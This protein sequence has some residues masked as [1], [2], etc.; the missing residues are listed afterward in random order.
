MFHIQLSSFLF[1][2]FFPKIQYRPTQLSFFDSSPYELSHMSPLCH[3]RTTSFASSSK[4]AGAKIFLWAPSGSW[5]RLCAAT[6]GAFISTVDKDSTVHLPNLHLP[7]HRDPHSSRPSL[8]DAGV[9][10][11][12]RRPR[13][14]RDA[15]FWRGSPFL[16]T[17]FIH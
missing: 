12:L 3:F 10:T 6:A 4:P 7:P 11:R 2:M 1:S 17:Y 9:A 14:R 15:R 8:Q 5:R 13:G 16:G